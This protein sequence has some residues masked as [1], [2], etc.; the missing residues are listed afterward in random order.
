MAKRRIV[1]AWQ[2]IRKKLLSILGKFR[3]FVDL[4]VQCQRV[5]ARDWGLRSTALRF[6]TLVF[7]R[8]RLQLFLMISCIIVSH[9]YLQS[10]KM[11]GCNLSL[12]GFLFA[13][14][15]LLVENSGSKSVP[16]ILR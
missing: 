14:N 4:A 8:Q 15:I 9:G 3:R 5:S 11:Q 2:I 16:A 12:T 6:C 10:E 1:V 13:E 7:R